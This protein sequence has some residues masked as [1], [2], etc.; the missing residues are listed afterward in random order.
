MGFFICSVKHWNILKTEP[1]SNE[2]TQ[3]Y[4]YLSFTSLLCMRS[5]CI[6]VLIC[7]DS[8]L[9][10]P[11]IRPYIRVPDVHIDTRQRTIRRLC[12]LP[13]FGVPPHI[14][15]CRGPDTTAINAALINSFIFVMNAENV[16]LDFLLLF[17]L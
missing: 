6:C 5:L 12:A 7:T 2:R 4:E 9:F 14:C 3:R 8:A 16:D 10:A 17:L 15:C 11:I 13:L 1:Q